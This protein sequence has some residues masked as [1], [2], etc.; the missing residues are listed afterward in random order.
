MDE[1]G[2]PNRAL[3]AD[4]P[5]LNPPEV[6]QARHSKQ[7]IRTVAS[8]LSLRFWIIVRFYRAVSRARPKFPL[9]RGLL[10]RAACPSLVV[11]LQTSAH[12]E[13]VCQVVPE[14]DRASR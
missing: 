3:A 8:V 7:S 10:L 9:Q 11:P 5:V 12:A 14:H 1:D 4:Y 13:P 6:G 2:P